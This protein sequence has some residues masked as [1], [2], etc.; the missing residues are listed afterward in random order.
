MHHWIE[1]LSEQ[2]RQT[3]FL[4]WLAVVLGVTE[5][6]L[7]RKNNILLYPAG[8]ISS[9][10]TIMLFFKAGLFADAGLNL[11]Y[12]IISFYG[13]IIWSRRKAGE[14][15]VKIAYASG[16]EW[17]TTLLIAFGGGIGIWLI[18]KHFTPS[19]VPLWDAWVTSSAWAG[20]YLLARR[21]IE[22]WVVLNVS[23]LFAIPLLFIKQLPL[24]ALLTI[25][26]FIAAV[27]GFFDWKKIYE[28]K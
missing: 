24:F 2:I 18:L 25:F 21:R 1:L 5:V 13:W 17:L 3:T 20:T 12:V 10:I 7:A 27:F 9:G 28:R 22:N 4:E 15:P 6:L 23:N 8:I 11:Y 16:K 14:K 26:L 19:T